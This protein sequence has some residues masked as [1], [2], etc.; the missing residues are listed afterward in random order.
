[1]LSRI[2][3]SYLTCDE[4]GEVARFSY[5]RKKKWDGIGWDGIRMT[6]LMHQLLDFSSERI[7][8]LGR[9]REVEFLLCGGLDIGLK[10]EEVGGRLE[11]DFTV[12]GIHFGGGL[13]AVAFICWRWG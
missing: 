2:G 12:V 3:I 7:F 11:V 1:M 6:D 5:S 10:V 9:D 8:P 13:E 4:T